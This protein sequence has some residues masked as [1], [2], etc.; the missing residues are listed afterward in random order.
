MRSAL[1]RKV[2]WLVAVLLLL[3]IPLTLVKGL[4]IERQQRAAEVRAEIADYAGHAQRVVGPLL[5][6]PYRLTT[7]TLRRNATGGEVAWTAAE[8]WGEVV[9]QPEELNA[10]FDLRTESLQRGIFSVPLFRSRTR[11]EGSYRV[12]P[13][14]GY[15]I[16]DTPEVQYAYEW[17][18]PRLVVGISDRRGIAN[19]AGTSG[20]SVLRFR[21]GSGLPWLDAGV[22]SGMAVPDAGGTVPFRVEVQVTGTESLTVM[23][24]AR[25]NSV[26]MRGSWPHPS[27]IGRFAP[28]RRSVT[29]EGFSVAWQ[30]DEWATGLSDGALT[31]CGRVD[32]CPIL[33]EVPPI[34]G[35]RLVDPVDHYLLSERT[36]KYGQLFIL[37]TFAA[38]FLVEAIKRLR[39]H[40]A[41]YLLVGLALALFFLMTL[42]LS[43]HLGFS[44]A[45]WLAAILCSALLGIYGAAILQSR[46]RG[47]GFTAALLSIYGLLFIILQSEDTALLLGSGLLFAVLAAIMLITR[48]IDWYAL[49]G[50]SLESEAPKA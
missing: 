24:I 21:P 4:V 36:T 48:R 44:A 47:A 14:V 35:V 41:Q 17:G 38:F 29:A 40:P 25:R 22:Q 23:P 10:D 13:R 11:L 16:A 42:S 37:L 30:T 15:Q 26:S 6:L 50:M 27:F 39:L 45:Y 19:L 33:G 43:E 34:A 12:A 18:Q 3:Y 7:R 32:V 9:L 1:G 49:P 31:G 5:V 28:V 2:A 20:S 46:W 8:S